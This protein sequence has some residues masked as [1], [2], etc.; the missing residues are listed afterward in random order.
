MP[1]KETRQMFMLALQRAGIDMQKTR[2]VFKLKGLYG[3]PEMWLYPKN[4]TG[5]VGTLITKETIADI[6]YLRE[7][8]HDFIYV[9]K[10][11]QT[12]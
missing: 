5:T 8:I 10:S 2:V 11:K 4:E 6:A 7:Y 3:E 12:I 1:E 9:P